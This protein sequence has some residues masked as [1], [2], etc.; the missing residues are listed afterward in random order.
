MGNPVK[1]KLRSG[2]RKTQMFQSLLIF[3]K[4]CL[5]CFPFLFVFIVIMKLIEKKIK[6][7][8]LKTKHGDSI[9]NLHVRTC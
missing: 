7:F 6:F 1:E 3:E 8:P 5:S 4:S 9:E 2:S